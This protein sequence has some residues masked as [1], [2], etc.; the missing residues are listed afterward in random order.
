MLTMRIV[1]TKKGSNW[2]NVQIE[3]IGN[4]DGL[5]G[6]EELTDYEI[7]ETKHKFKDNVG[8]SKLKKKHKKIKN[9]DQKNEPTEVVQDLEIE[10]S[11]ILPWTNIF[12]PEEIANSLVKQGFSNPTE[13]QRQCIPAAIKGRRDILGAAETGSGKTLAFGIPMLYGILKCLENELP[14]E[15]DSEEEDFEPPIKNKKCVRVIHLSSEKKIGSL[16]GLVLTPTRE[17]ALQIKNHLDITAKYT[18]VKV[19]VVVGGMSVEKQIRILKKKPH[20]L[21][22]TPG[23]L[24]E[25]MTQEPNLVNLN[26]IRFFTID[27]TDRM[28]E[29][30]HFPELRSILEILQEHKKVKRQNFVFSAT[31]TLVH[32]PPSYIKRKRHNKA[33]LTQND[34]LKKLIKAVGMKDYKVVDITKKTGTA[35]ALKEAK[36]SCTFDEKDYYIYYLLK[37][38]NGRT[39]IFCNSIS[40][41]R[42]LA[43]LLSLL[44]CSPLPLHANMQQ[45]QRLKNLDRFKK[46][47]NSVLLSTDVA[48]RGLDIP[49]IDHVI[50]YQ[51]PRT[52]EGYIHRSGRTARANK[53]GLTILLIEP[54]EVKSYIKICNT[55]GRE[56]D[57]DEFPVEQNLLLE[58]KSR[59]KIARDVDILERKLIKFNSNISWL[60]KSAEELDLVLDD[61]QIPKVSN[62]EVSS[63]K[64]QLLINKKQLANL[65]SKPL[66]SKS[67]A[68]NT[69][70]EKKKVIKKMKFLKQK[71]HCT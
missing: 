54:N 53:T 67:T 20:L 43:S 21:V 58:A 14:V 31:L 33:Q 68:I 16:L 4:F 49:N 25:L 3:G 17:L 8:K 28:L 34:K 69:Q 19:A 47:D 52:S 18:A 61:E 44:S 32:E 15:V 30:D 40:C 24:W 46:E 38:Y 66:I 1:Q 29:R 39:V 56:K 26:N 59:V 5:V 50:H 2:G 41:V 23:R 60:E 22:A 10:P 65:L 11:D 51:V 37:A 27:E 13:I 45:R 42:R 71:L 6:I 62:K 63:A 57:V 35:A 55:L 7:K 70:N 64:H 36:I 12:V 9:L 48:A